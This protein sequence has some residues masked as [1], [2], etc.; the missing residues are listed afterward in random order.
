MDRRTRAALRAL[1]VAGAEGAMLRYRVRHL[2]EALRGSGGRTQTVRYRDPR[3]MRL[4]CSA[5]VLVLYRVPMT[6]Q[7]D[8]LLNRVMTQRPDLPVI[9]D[10]D[11]L[12]FDVNAAKTAPAW[13]RM[14]EKDR[15]GWLRGVERYRETLVR[16]DVATVSTSALAR[17]VESMGIPA[18]VVPNGL[19][20]WLARRS[21]EVLARRGPR[22]QNAVVV[23]Y[24]SG[25]PTH[26][27]DW[28]LIEDAVADALSRHPS[29]RLL[30]VGHLTPSRSLL[31]IGA[32]R[33]SV[34]GP[35]S[36]RRLPQLLAEADVVLAPLVASEFN[37]A[38]SGV[39]W[40]EAAAVLVPTIASPRSGMVEAV[41]DPPTAWLAETEREWSSALDAVAARDSSFSELA[42]GARRRAFDTYGERQR[43][44]QWLSALGHGGRGRARH[45]AA[46][47]GVTS[48][49][50][51]ER[52]TRRLPEPYPFI[53]HPESRWR[54]H[55]AW[56]ASRTRVTSSVLG[57]YALSAVAHARS[58]RFA[59]LAA[60]AARVL[61]RGGRPA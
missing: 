8:D 48:P 60:G 35:V 10:V 20:R 46:E 5:D 24:F 43:V 57:D 49:L 11:D 3:L 22:P 53:E 28:A 56:E 54:D 4:A 58:G 19:G 55:M 33:V 25:S 42:Q 51:D 9:F 13:A 45:P 61:N 50:M 41:G 34:V 37:D 47:D 59:D 1:F 12:I 52:W 38:K 21:A 7:L 36:W 6:R 26:D 30:L 15:A 16:C 29:M 2:E 23:G 27:A 40:L 31:S 17:H 32:G 18:L 14:P 39:K 44:N